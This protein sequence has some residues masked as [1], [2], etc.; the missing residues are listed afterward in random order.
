MNATRT[1]PTA[2]ER[3]AEEE[4]EE[5][6]EV[7]TMA[8]L[9]ALQGL[10][11]AGSDPEMVAMRAWAVAA[12]FVEARAHWIDALDELIDGAPD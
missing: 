2:A 5:I 10:L 8:A 7:G 12:G 3:A 1:Q 4:K 11:A 9:A 6:I